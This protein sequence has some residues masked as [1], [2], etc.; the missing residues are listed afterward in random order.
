MSGVRGCWTRRALLPAPSIATG[1]LHGLEL[2]LPRRKAAITL[3]TGNSTANAGLLRAGG[4]RHCYGSAVLG[5]E[6]NIGGW[7]I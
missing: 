4:G 3:P 7:R 5:K 2:H 1:Q 6:V